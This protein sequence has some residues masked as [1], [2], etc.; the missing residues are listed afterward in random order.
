MSGGM[1]GSPLSPLDL[2]D[3]IDRLERRLNEAEGRERGTGRRVWSGGAQPL[4]AGAAEMD[5]GDIAW[6][7]LNDGRIELRG[8]M[9]FSGSVANGTRILRLPGLCAPL[10]NGTTMRAW[11]TTLAP[12]SSVG[13]N[14]GVVRVDVERFLVSEPYEDAGATKTQHVVYA[15]IIA[16][17]PEAMPLTGWI[18]FDHV[19]YDPDLYLDVLEP[20]PASDHPIIF[21]RGSEVEPNKWAIRDPLPAEFGIAV[22]GMDGENPIITIPGLQA[23]NQPTPL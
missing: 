21:G 15:D 17:P 9:S 1:V 22:L 4:V 18:C 5:G 11:V 6:R 14:P 19:I 20:V 23:P 10:G 2:S 8:R 3:Y 7:K 16:R 13:S 12:C